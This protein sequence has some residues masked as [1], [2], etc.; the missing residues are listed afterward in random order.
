MS[1][2][3]INSFCTEEWKQEK[4]KNIYID[5]SKKMRV[6]VVHL[7]R[8]KELLLNVYQKNPS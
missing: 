2:D 4:Y 7:R 5:R 3:E 8:A 6:N 1:Y